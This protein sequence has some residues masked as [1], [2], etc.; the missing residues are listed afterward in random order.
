MSARRSAELYRAG[1]VPG[2][3]GFVVLIAILLPLRLAWP[4]VPP[5]VVGAITLVVCLG[6]ALLWMVLRDPPDTALDQ[7]HTPERVAPG[8][9]RSIRPTGAEEAEGG[10]AK[11]WIYAGLAVFAAVVFTVLA[12]GDALSH[13][14]STVAAIRFGEALAAWCMAALIYFAGLRRR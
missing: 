12:F 2:F 5:L 9:G 3:I 4:D 10:R 8:P 14:W 6:G 11:L 7:S 1:R 13:G